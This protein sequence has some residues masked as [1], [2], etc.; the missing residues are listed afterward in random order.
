MITG[1]SIDTSQ[2]AAMVGQIYWP[3]VRI[4]GLVMVAPVFGAAYVT[5]RIKAGLIILLTVIIIPGTD[6]VP[7]VQP[8]SAE[9]LLITATQL[10]IGVSI[11]Y[12][13]LLVFNAIVVGGEAI[14]TTMGLGYALINDPSN[15]VQVPILSQFYT[16]FA[17]LLFLAL[18]GHHVLIEL[19][20]V[21]FDYLPVGTR[22]NGDMLWT[23]IDWS[24]VLF[25]GALG[26]AIPAL[27]SMLTVNLIMGIMTRASPQLNI[28]SIGFPVTMTIGF[29][30]IL[31]TLP[32]VASSFESLLDQ[33]YNTISLW[34]EQ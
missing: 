22:I 29:V 32:V 14:A 26:I 12:M 31:M 5:S 3:L 18:N 30:V 10:L 9:A 27:A 11:G 20:T 33:G 8:L 19:L 23:I 24:S 6:P 21:S 16:V 4:A 7:A 15:G 34:L 25:I 2:L 1:N 17:T 13:I 28:F